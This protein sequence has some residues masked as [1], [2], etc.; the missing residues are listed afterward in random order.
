[1]QHLPWWQWIVASMATVAG[2][3]PSAGELNLSGHERSSAESTRSTD[4]H[5]AERGSYHSRF[6]SLRIVLV[7]GCLVS[8]LLSFPLWTN[9]RAF[10][11]LPVLNGWPVLPAPWDTGLA[12]AAMASLALAW[13]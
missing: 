6:R 13:R 10:P 2:E 11:L 8:M 3:A 9:A 7:A 4:P 12:V 1:M 5:D